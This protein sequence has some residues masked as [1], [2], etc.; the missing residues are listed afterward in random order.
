MLVQG[1]SDISE[2]RINYH[3]QGSLPDMV[4][5]LGQTSSSYSVLQQTKTNQQNITYPASV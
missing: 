1:M 2:V 5:A 3:T 4:V